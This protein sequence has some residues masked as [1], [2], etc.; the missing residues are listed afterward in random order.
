LEFGKKNKDKNNLNYLAAFH[1]LNIS[2]IT[3]YEEEQNYICIE[4]TF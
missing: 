2:V 3:I 1:T 4:A